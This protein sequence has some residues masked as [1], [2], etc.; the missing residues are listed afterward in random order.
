M[1]TDPIKPKAMSSPTPAAD[2]KRGA[3]TEV[4]TGQARDLCDLSI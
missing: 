1:V 2:S 4:R 3:T